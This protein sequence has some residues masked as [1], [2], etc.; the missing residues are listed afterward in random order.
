[1][2]VWASGVFKFYAH[3]ERFLCCG[4][5]LDFLFSLT[6]D[7]LSFYDNIFHKSPSNC[8]VKF[9]VSCCILSIHG[10]SRTIVNH[11]SVFNQPEVLVLVSNS[12]C[13]V[14]DKNVLDVLF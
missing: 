7:F 12:G 11:R 4:E 10:K 13:H 9:I 2:V 14:N 8:C 1:M 5:H 6:K 3:R